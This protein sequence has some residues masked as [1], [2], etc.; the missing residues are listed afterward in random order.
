MSS[1]GPAIRAVCRIINQ[2]S[3][4][5]GS[6]CG[7]HPDNGAFVLTNAHVA[8]TRIGRIV[9]VEVE[10]LGRR[11]FNGRVIR[12]AYSNSV[13]A[14]WAL[15]HVPGLTEV[16]PVYLTRELPKRGESMYTKGFPRCQPHNGTDIEQFTTLNNGVLLWEPDAIG[17]Q[18]GSAVWGD[19]DHVQKALLTWSMNYRG[20]WRGAGQLTAEIW[21]QNRDFK[22]T[23]SLRG[24]ARIPDA[25]YKELPHEF[26]L[27]DTEP[28]RDDPE[29]REGIF[30]ETINQGI[31][32]YPIWLETVQPTD[33]EPDPEDPPTGGSSSKEHLASLTR[34]QAQVEDEIER[35]HSADSEVVNPND[36]EDGSPTFGL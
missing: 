35:L 26:D 5:S 13:S 1:T 27:G 23:R 33:P 30:S 32:D 8:G 17:G 21:K 2:N 10:S 20:R 3:C 22:L 31:Q 16:K 9:S 36:P 14:D 24:S 6:I 28:G 34:I 4:G 12:A 18:S 25:E 7:Y 15:L 29:I 19:A 11:R